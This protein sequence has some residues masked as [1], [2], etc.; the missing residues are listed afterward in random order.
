MS[1]PLTMVDVLELR[2]A[3]SG[4]VCAQTFLSTVE[5]TPTSQT[6]GQ[7]WARACA[8]ADCLRDGA[9][10]SDRA[11]VMLEPGHDYVQSFF[12]CML[13]GIIA[14]PS[15]TPR[16][17][18][19]AERVA[20]IIADSRPRVMVVNRKSAAR[21]RDLIEVTPAAIW[22][23]V[24]V[25]E[26][27]PDGAASAPR[28][29]PRPDDLAFIQYTSGS[30][31]APR[32]VMV[33]HGNI[34][35]NSEFIRERFRHTSE[36]RGVIW[37]PPY[38]DMGLIGGILQPIYSGFPVHL[39]SPFRFLQHPLNWLKCISE[40]RGTT[41]GGPD[42][43]Y[44]MC[45]QR[46]PENALDELDLSSWQVA[47][48]GGEP[49]RRSTMVRFARK[50]ARCGFRQNAFFPCYGLAEATLMVTG[51]FFDPGECR[52]NRDGVGDTVSCG[53]SASDQVV[54][55]VDPATGAT[56]A[57]GGTA[58]IWVKGPGVAAGYWGGAAEPAPEFAGFIA[59]DGDG[60]YV[61]TGD[62]GF[63]AGGRLYVSGRRKDLIIIRG[64][65]LSPHDIEHLAAETHPKIV[66]AG[67]AAFGLEHEQGERL[68]CLAEVHKSTTENEGKD[69]RGAIREA[70][71]QGVGVMPHDIRLVRPYTLPRTSSGKLQRFLCAHLYRTEA[72]TAHVPVERER[73]P[74]S[75]APATP[76]QDD[77]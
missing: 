20:R 1:A 59:S 53:D 45:I 10:K 51:G 16:N 68:V 77:T 18:R 74:V 25:V 55:I 48:S 5:G 43:C 69:I 38:H 60:P 33:T 64:R 73:T 24:V 35:W 58:E 2:A 11:L 62:I 46:I 9:E 23:R 13:A 42:F 28:L 36:S 76:N 31:R 6:Y 44:E 54:R 29:R 61:R 49:V 12:G 37:L 65:N 4:A 56:C 26:D 50:F 30:T 32:G 63:M 21:M 27:I 7:L 67:V 72:L 52:P 75:L 8:I 57:P 70:V 66:A 71:G 34:T 17:Q 14:V 15:Y 40:T 41:S 39:M 3:Q 47:F 22:P 19:E